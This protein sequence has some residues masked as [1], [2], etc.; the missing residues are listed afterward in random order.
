MTLSLS[1][2]SSQVDLDLFLVNANCGAT[3]ARF[4]GC[5]VFAESVYGGSGPEIIG[6]TV[7]QGDT[8]RI[9][10]DNPYFVTTNYTLTINIR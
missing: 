3:T 9:A 1:W 10:V 5:E 7:S 4:D 2:P 6:R 8:F